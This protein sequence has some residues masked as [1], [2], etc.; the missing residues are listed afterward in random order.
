MK[1]IFFLLFGIVLLTQPTMA[2]DSLAQKTHTVVTA[3]GTQTVSAEQQNKELT[4][5]LKKMNQDRKDE[6]DQKRTEKYTY[7]LIGKIVFAVLIVGAVALWR[8]R[9]KGSN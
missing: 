9:K 5:R 7:K 2:Q 1:H 4:D 8:S 3:N 6:R